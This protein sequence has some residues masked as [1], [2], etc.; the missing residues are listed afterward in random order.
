MPKRF[1]LATR[2]DRGEQA[3]PL[4]EA[5]KAHGWERTPSRGNEARSKILPPIVIV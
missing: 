4:L 2:K 5:L 3:A 1:Y